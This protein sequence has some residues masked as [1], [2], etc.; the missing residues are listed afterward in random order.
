M[1]TNYFVSKLNFLKYL[2]YIM[3]NINLNNLIN[4]KNNMKI[5]FIFKSHKI[6]IIGASN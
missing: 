4:N 3:Q 2:P 1:K 5:D 6:Y